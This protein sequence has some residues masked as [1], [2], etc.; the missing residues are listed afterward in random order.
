MMELSNNL[1]MVVITQVSKF[2]KIIWTVYFKYNF[3]LC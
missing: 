1:I 2:I 3:I